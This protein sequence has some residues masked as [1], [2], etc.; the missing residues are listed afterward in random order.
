MR[1][2]FDRLDIDPAFRVGDEGEMLLMR[3]DVMDGLLED[4]TATAGKGMR[5][6]WTRMRRARRTVELPS[7]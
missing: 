5:S 1:E 7:M 4:I 2:H 3:A 6:L